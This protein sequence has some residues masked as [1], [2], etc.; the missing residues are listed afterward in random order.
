[1]GS[2]EAREF[3]KSKIYDVQK[4]RYVSVERKDVRYRQQNTTMKGN[5]TKLQDNV[6]QFPQQYTAKKGTAH[7]KAN[8]KKKKRKMRLRIASLILAAG[9]GVGG[10][11]YA[12]SIIKESQTASLVQMQENGISAKELGLEDTT[13]SMLIHYDKYF[14]NSEEKLD[15]TDN[16]VIKIIDDI[17]YLNN[18]VLKE[19]L[20]KTMGVGKDN[21]SLGEDFEISDGK[22]YSVIRVTPK[23]GNDEIYTS[24]SALPFAIGEK[25][26]IPKDISELI[27]QRNEYSKLENDL[28]SDS[29]TKNRAMEELS[30]LYKKIQNIATKKIYLDKNKN[31]KVESYKDI[32]KSLGNER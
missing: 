22:E 29:I 24:L 11:S 7:S 26:N 13:A 12:G 30:K 2:E 5:T 3:R 18:A 6:I 19:K 31:L 32:E 17:S 20:S 10:L 16:D 14:S 27:F 9:I 1:M 25:R 23:Y 21:I 4:D 8:T 15:M 28:K